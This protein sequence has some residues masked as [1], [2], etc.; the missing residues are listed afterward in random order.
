MIADRGCREYR[1]VGIKSSSVPAG[2]GT[3]Q[4]N[5]GWSVSRFDIDGSMSFCVDFEAE[6]SLFHRL[7]RCLRIVSAWNTDWS[8]LNRSRYRLAGENRKEMPAGRYR[9]LRSRNN[10]SR[11]WTRSLLSVVHHVPVGN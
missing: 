11:Q 6:S 7:Q 9:G 2:R 8:V 4:N 5:A 3:P 1:L 10:R